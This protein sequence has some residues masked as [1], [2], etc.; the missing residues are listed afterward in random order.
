M[1]IVPKK[2]IDRLTTGIALAI[3]FLAA[4]G[5]E[6]SKWVADL[7]R[8]T[9]F[10]LIGFLFGVLLKRSNFTRKI[11][12]YLFLLYTLNLFL[13]LYAFS[14]HTD[15]P[16]IERLDAFFQNIHEN[17]KILQSGSALER[18]YLFLFFSGLLFW[19]L[20]NVLGHSLD[21]YENYW[22]PILVLSIVFIIQQ[23]FVIPA[24]RS[25]LLE[26][27]YF[28]LVFILIA[29]VEYLKSESRWLSRSF[30]FDEEIWQDQSNR[31]LTIL[32]VLAVI[33]WSFP[34]I[35]RAF[36]PGT[37]ESRALGERIQNVST[38]V[39]NFFSGFQ[40]YATGGDA[41]YGEFLAVNGIQ[42]I[43]EEIQYSFEMMGSINSTEQLYWRS[44]TYDEYVSPFW[45]DSIS[46]TQ[47]I[48]S[49]ELINLADGV[50]GKQVMIQINKSIPKA[51]LPFP[52]LLLSVNR[53][54]E[55][56]AQGANGDALDIIALREHIPNS[57]S[58]RVAVYLPSFS[59]NQ[60]Q[61]SKNIYPEWVRQSYL[62]IEPL[63]K[64]RILP[65]VTQ[66]IYEHDNAFDQSQAI[67]NYL[68]TQYSYSISEITSTN[69]ADPVI[70]FLFNTK[71]GFCNQFASANVLMLRSV[72]IP[73]RLS[74]GYS[75]GV[76]GFSGKNFI[77][78]E[79]DRHAW[80][81]VYFP[82]YG[83]VIFEPTPNLPS[84]MDFRTP[85][86][87]AEG[88]PTTVTR[89]SGDTTS[90]LS[91]DVLNTLRFQRIQDLFE[92]E[93]VEARNQELNFQLK[94]GIFIE[95]NYAGLWLTFAV[96]IGLLALC[97][98]LFRLPSIPALIIQFN[99][100]LNSNPPKSAI[101]WGKWL[102]LNGLERD[103]FV[104]ENLLVWLH[105]P[106]TPPV[107]MQKIKANIEQLLPEKKTQISLLFSEYER[108]IYSRDKTNLLLM[109]RLSK[110]ISRSLIK[111]GIFFRI[112]ALKF[113]HK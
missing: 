109:H 85:T 53:N 4:Y 77:V 83:W 45:E 41:E 112:K 96:L 34:S 40:N 2:L 74:V 72:G 13:L 47:P 92:I 23:L 102:V 21:D 11:K 62:N 105:Q 31:T 94:V 58:M 106:I 90:S 55:L 50:P 78:R 99:L 76:V 15:L 36:S 82:G 100:I 26:A 52:G 67:T 68:R 30:G 79:K 25:A 1:E 59:E 9:T 28:V 5:L 63:I 103:Y 10:A 88:D 101:F 56:L 54:A 24:N 19:V 12:I 86:Q 73:A 60:L 107:T 29:R 22:K 61:N 46:K 111:K 91:E 35:A 17:I 95:R 108:M 39:R 16:W 71:V 18:N 70:D 43:S 64:A 7:N 113:P 32:I 8:T 44:R 38:T 89:D 27:L 97:W 84:R 80:P 110:D 48:S 49:N 93:G 75:Q 37:R 66:I 87:N 98:R 65:L 104:L 20:S 42:P 69:E 33:A 3:V 14:F 51:Y 6:S 57:E 81:E